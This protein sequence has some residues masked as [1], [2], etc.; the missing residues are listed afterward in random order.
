MRKLAAVLVGAALMMA[1]SAM[2]TPILDFGVIAPTLGSI[3]YA[4]GAA[5][6]V[7]SG[8]EVDNVL[9]MDTLLNN[10]IGFDILGGVLNFTTG[11]MTSGSASAVNFG[12][13]NNSSITL[14]GT[15]DVDNSGT[16]NTGD[17][18]GMLMS[19]SFGTASVITTNGEFRI[20][21]AGFYDYK[22]PELLEL[23]GLPVYQ[24]NST[25]PL[26]YAGAFNISFTASDSNLLD[27]FTSTRVLSGDITNSPV[28]EPGTMM[29]LGLGIFGLAIFGKRRMNKDA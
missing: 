14:Y 8:I 13:S 12:G 23:Y 20:A 7:G 27:G 6:L 10:N 11:N 9:G 1:T 2:A 28:P 17:I 4:G 22:L 5:P 29:L 21:G 18:T 16:V 24:T 15:V 26:L 25:I 19:G 3:S